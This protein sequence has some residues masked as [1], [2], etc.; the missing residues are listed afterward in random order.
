M[1]TLI[2]ILSLMLIMSF[3]SSIVGYK[4]PGITENPSLGKIKLCKAATG[5]HSN[6]IQKYVNSGIV[7]KHNKSDE[8]E[9]TF[10]VN[11][12]EWDKELAESQEVAAIGGWCM[13][14]SKYGIGK[15]FIYDDKTNKLIGKVV[16]GNYE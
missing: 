9:Y 8:G 15:V 3:L 2:V 4:I 12:K 1:R 5:M 11:K 7:I 6:F 14:A 16:D 10:I 13:V